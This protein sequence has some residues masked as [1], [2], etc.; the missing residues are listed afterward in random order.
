MPII[1]FDG[2]CNLCNS[3]VDSLI[4]RDKKRALKFASLQGATA[5][6]RLSAAIVNDLTTMVYQDGEAILTES[7]AAVRAVAALGGVYRL[8]LVLLV[9]P[10]GL[11]NVV[12]RWIAR[13]RY[14][15]FGKRETCRLPTVEE[16]AQFL[17]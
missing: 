13:R 8:L 6:A 3:F 11:R 1:Y 12:Y 14:R 9:V 17:Q 2:Y 16:R 7:T 15:F 10:A 5:R 4:R